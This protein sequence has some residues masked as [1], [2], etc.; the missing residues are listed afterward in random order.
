MLVS[1]VDGVVS[2][3]TPSVHSVLGADP[4]Q[5]LGTRWVDLVDI[6]DR[7][8]LLRQL[9]SVRAGSDAAVR[10]RM[11][12]ADGRLL[13]LSGTLSN[14][15]DDAA[16]EGLV[17]TVRDVTAQVQLETELTHQAFHDAL[18]GIANRQLF[19]DRLAHAL[20]QRPRLPGE[21]SGLVVLFLDLDE[22][23]L[24]ND[25]LGHGAGDQVLIEVGQPRRRRNPPRRHGG[26][27]RR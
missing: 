20:E 17:L 9:S 13:H 4:E 15:L 10:V 25:S 3:V 27:P 14:L 1:D 18:T 16:V 21:E 26:P 7:E 11:H 5:L 19:T 24:V 23:K 2:F 6:A 12:H 8:Q 22:F